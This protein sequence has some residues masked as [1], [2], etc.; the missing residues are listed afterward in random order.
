M[1][2]PPLAPGAH[3][4][5]ATDNPDEWTWAEARPLLAPGARVRL[6]EWDGPVFEL[7]EN[8]TWTDDVARLVAPVEERAAV[9]VRLAAEA[10]GELV[11]LP[12]PPSRPTLPAALDVPDDPV[13]VRVRDALVEAGARSLGLLVDDLRANPSRALRRLRVAERVAHV[14]REAVAELGLDDEEDGGVGE[15]YQA[16]GLGDGRRRRRRPGFAGGHAYGGQMDQQTAL[17]GAVRAQHMQA[18]TQTIERTAPNGPAPH[19]GVHE[20]AV[21]ELALLFPGADAPRP[22]DEPAGAPGGTIRGIEDAP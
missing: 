18:L 19:P 22:P 13:E 17:N 10:E 11:A 3:L 9:L 12:R 8:G 1:P 20:A 14:L 7:Q 16:M 5:M 21:R 4:L 6:V 15:D 2:R